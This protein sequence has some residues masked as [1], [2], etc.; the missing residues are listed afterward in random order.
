MTGVLA[1]ARAL[2]F[3]SAILVFGELAFALFV[4][5]SRSF[6]RE[7]SRRRF[8]RVVSWSIAASIASWVVWLGCEAVEMSG[9]SIKQAL[10]SQTLL[11]VLGQTEFGRLWLLRLAL[12]AVLSALLWTS[13]RK[14]VDEGHRASS[15]ATF[16]IAGAYLASLAWA[17]HAAAGAERGVQLTSDALHL[18]AAGAWLGALPALA[19]LLRSGSEWDG[20]ALAARRFGTLGVVSV[21]LL[22]LT[23]FINAWYLVGDIPA[24]IGTAYG[25]LLLVKLALLAAMLALAAN[26]R[27]ALTPR[28]SRGNA[29]DAA[30]LGRNALMETGAGAAI[31]AIVGVLGITIPGAHQSPV[32]PFSRG[33]DLEP[34]YPTSYASSPVPYTTNAIVRGGALYAQQCVS[35]HGVHGH[36][37]GPSAA[38]LPTKPANLAEHAAF[39]RPGD[40]YWFIARGVP[41]TSMRGFATLLG[42]TDIWSVVRFL[43]ALSDSE[44]VS[45]TAD[46]ASP[47]RPIVAP[48]FVFQV[49]GQAQESLARP[50]Q[51]EMTLL[52][53]YTLPQSLPRLRALQAQTREYADHAIRVIAV[54][55]QDSL[56]GAQAMSSADFARTLTSPDVTAVYAMFARSPQSEV[57]VH[58]EF[59]I[60]A[61]GFMRRRWLDVPGES[62]NRTAE[63]LKQADAVAR[64]PPLTATEKSHAH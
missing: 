53:F 27:F 62:A 60:D 54:P 34:A 1:A 64:A 14:R 36:G 50:R 61:R 17:G 46:A 21:T 31:V 44:T 41:G 15:V 39:H 7:E 56:S 47:S 2:H 19:A 35:C 33:L 51:R 37:D 13:T 4:A 45:E 29:A 25:Q 40:L 30:R 9:V 38:S 16:A 6:E 52:V 11:L 42:D 10:G 63:I 58:V 49:G 43:R 20:G 28:L 24:L 59:L 48:D 22:L 18:L 23:G 12:A 55:L 57:V 5:D 26:N 3:A 8:H 32:W